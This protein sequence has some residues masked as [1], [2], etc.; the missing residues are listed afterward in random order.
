MTHETSISAQAVRV[1]RLQGIATL[2]VATLGAYFA[3]LPGALSAL[4]GGAVVM[5]GVVI[6]TAIATRRALSAGSA[7]VT[8]LKAE[9]IKIIVIAVGLLAIFKLYRGL[10]PW[11]L[12]GGLAAAALIAGAAFQGPE[13]ENNG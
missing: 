1:L 3:G 6:A 12:I 4:A 5:L 9:A 10:V 13:K 2:A 7:L 11:A 8:L